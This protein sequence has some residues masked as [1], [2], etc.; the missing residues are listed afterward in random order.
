MT[1]PV[2]FAPVFKGWNVWS[3]W[4]ADDPDRSVLEALWMAGVE[5]E[6]ALR[7]WVEDQVDDN[8]P[9]AVVGDPV[10]P[11]PKKFKGEMVKV[12]PNANGLVQA[13][14]RKDVP[15]LEGAQQL[16]EEGSGARLFFVR[17]YNRG[18]S[19]ALPWPH[20]KNFLVESVYQPDAT[21]G[22]T[23]SPPPGSAA[24][25][26]EHAAAA[27]SGALVPVALIVGGVAVLFILSKLGSRSS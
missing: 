9:G 13:S 8:A 21:N 26:I 11:N 10:S 4:Q 7:I 6:R 19:S 18:E 20:D 5:P 3:L 24:E 22:L 1:A 15:G 17:F 12:V 2:G 16:G 14:I 25:D 27:V 23:N